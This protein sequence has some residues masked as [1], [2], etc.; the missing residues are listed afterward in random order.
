MKKLI[1]IDELNCIILRLLNGFVSNE[2]LIC[3]GLNIYVSTGCSESLICRV[4]MSGSV[5]SGFTPFVFTIE[6]KQ[7]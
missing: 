6:V 3:I 4:K 2:W 5:R 1:S 7:D